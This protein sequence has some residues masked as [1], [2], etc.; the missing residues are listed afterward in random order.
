MKIPTKW[1]MSFFSHI[2]E[3]IYV[4]SYF[5]FSL[6][7]DWIICTKI[8]YII[9]TIEIIYKYTYNWNI[10]FQRIILIHF[11]LQL[12]PEKILISKRMRNSQ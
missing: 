10:I 4:H 7:T 12:F 8:S 3:H 9:Y 6:K 11:S 5:L 1:P 2:N